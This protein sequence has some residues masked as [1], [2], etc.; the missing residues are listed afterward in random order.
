MPFPSGVD[1]RHCALVAGCSRGP[2][3]TSLEELGGVVDV[4][5]SVSISS[6]VTREYMWH[7]QSLLLDDLAVEH[8]DD[9]VGLAPDRDVVR[10]DEEA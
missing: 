5:R 3:A 4:V 8:A 2:A 10:D 1:E 7:L 6:S 9:P